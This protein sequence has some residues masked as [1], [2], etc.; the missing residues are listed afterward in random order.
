MVWAIKSRDIH[1][2]YALS[3]ALAATMYPPLIAP[4]SYCWGSN[5]DGMGDPLSTMEEG[6]TCSTTS[7]HQL[8]GEVGEP[9]REGEIAIPC[10][11]IP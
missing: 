6:S 4:H 8:G 1:S 11:S 2:A 5:L 9:E 3:R 10:V 7:S